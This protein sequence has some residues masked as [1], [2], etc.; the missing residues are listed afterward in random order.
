M[1][2]AIFGVA[3][4]PQP[5]FL[6]V[7]VGR[8]EQGSRLNYQISKHMDL[9]LYYIHLSSITTFQYLHKTRYLISEGM[10]KQRLCLTGHNDKIADYF[11]STEM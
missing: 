5:S 2:Q 7:C 9:Q 11:T 10:A 8:G 3:H 1:N 6:S 4:F